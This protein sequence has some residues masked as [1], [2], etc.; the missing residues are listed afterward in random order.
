M[1]PLLAYYTLV[2]P[3]WKPL[4]I[5]FL[6]VSLSIF[7]FFSGYSRGLDSKSRD[8][9]IQELNHQIEL[10]KDQLKQLDSILQEKEKQLHLEQ[11]NT[12]VVTEYKTK[13]VT[14]EKEKP[15]YE[16]RIKEIFVDRP[17]EY[18]D[19]KLV[20][21]HDDFVCSNQTSSNESSCRTDG[22][23]EEPVTTEQF[24]K[25]VIDN[26]QTAVDNQNKLDAIQQQIKL[27]QEIIQ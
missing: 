3:F 6:G 21:L 2:K 25:T 11:M 15:V 17:T 27:Q 13:Q 20:R 14:I 24:V 19:P 9:Q 12:K 16:T 26:Y 10:Q 18:V 23:T 4:I 22:T 7:S 1:N 5:T 8:T